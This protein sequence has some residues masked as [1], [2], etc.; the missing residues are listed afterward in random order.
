M[1]KILRQMVEVLINRFVMSGVGRSKTLQEKSIML[2]VGLPCRSRSESF[3][4]GTAGVQMG[5]VTSFRGVSRIVSNQC[6]QPQ[7]ASTQHA[8][9]SGK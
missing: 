3:H 5:S 6:L 2:Y 4:V 1:E 9:S 8:K 7:S